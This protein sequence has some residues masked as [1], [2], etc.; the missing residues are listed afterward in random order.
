LGVKHEGNASAAGARVRPTQTRV[1]VLVIAGWVPT[2]WAAEARILHDCYTVV[3]WGS[4]AHWGR[5]PGRTSA[6]V[7]CSLGS[8]A[9]P[10]LRIVDLRQYHF[11][12]ISPSSVRDGRPH[13]PRFLHHPLQCSAT[14]KKERYDAGQ[15]RPLFTATEENH[16]CAVTR[17]QSGAVS[18]LAGGASRC[19]CPAPAK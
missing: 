5:S 6:R 3:V 19:V 9:L 12:P 11:T 1:G 18:P 14:D 13:T 7:G 8:S 17:G 2:G 16:P 15:W 10:L 4:V